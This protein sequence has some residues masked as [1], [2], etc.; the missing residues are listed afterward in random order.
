MNKFIFAAAAL[1]HPHFIC[2]LFRRRP[3]ISHA[4]NGKLTICG[5]QGVYTIIWHAITTVLAINSIALFHA[6]ISQKF[7]IAFASLISAQYFSW[8]LL[9]VFFGQSRLGELWTLPQ[10]IAFSSSPRLQFG[11]LKKV[12]KN[13]HHSY[14]N[15]HSSNGYG[16]GSIRLGLWHALAR[17]RSTIPGQ[18]CCLGCK[19]ISTPTLFHYIWCSYRYLCCRSFRPLGSTLNQSALTSMD[20]KNFGYCPDPDFHYSRH[21]N[22]YP[23]WSIRPC[24]GAL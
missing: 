13:D 18:H 24:R 5:R 11:A 19:Y 7:R 8:G 14:C 17:H 10:W 16:S 4:S 12:N 20:A 9:F 3:A 1:F 21:H 6:A 2:P 23:Q 22:L 15:I